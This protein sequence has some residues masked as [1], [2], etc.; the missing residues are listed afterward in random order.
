MIKPVALDVTPF[1]TNLFSF[2]SLCP[3]VTKLALLYKTKPAPYWSVP[4][5]LLADT[6]QSNVHR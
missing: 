2:L 5:R 1:W 6:H 3:T 4:D